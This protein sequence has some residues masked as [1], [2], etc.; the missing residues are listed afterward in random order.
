M[1]QEQ[2]IG[3]LNNELEAYIEKMDFRNMDTVSL[4]EA[5]ERI[6]RMSK[7]IESLQA[8][9]VDQ[10]TLLYLTSSPT[11]LQDIA[12]IWETHEEVSIDYE[13]LS[14]DYF[15]VPETIQDIL[16]N[17]LFDEYQQ[18]HDTTN[19]LDRPNEGAEDKA[20]FLRKA[21]N[22]QELRDYSAD[23]DQKQQFRAV[24]TIVLSP[25]MYDI[26]RENLLFDWAVTRENANLVYDGTLW[27][28]ALIR[29]TDRKEAICVSPE[30]HDYARYA[31]YIA[32]YTALPL[33]GVPV[34][35]CSP[36]IEAADMKRYVNQEQEDLSITQMQKL[37]CG[38]GEILENADGE[39][40]QYY[41]FSHAMG[42]FA[43]FCGDQIGVNDIHGEPL[44][45]GDMTCLNGNLDEPQLVFRHP[46]GEPFPSQEYV[47]EA[48]VTRLDGWQESMMFLRSRDFAVLSCREDYRMSR[49]I[50]A[51]I[52]TTRQEQTRS[53]R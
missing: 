14:I 27:N 32:D 4:V 3:L 8:E 42:S 50:A 44:S 19:D 43:G 51:R 23:Q 37:L 38:I 7:V 35:Y 26:F 48:G 13:E 25:A 53:G 6:V 17:G 10:D 21:P 16:D 18:N 45:V 9:P 12:E 5:A 33:S 39:Q 30:G 40:D 1:D 41:L 34:E 28:C 46:T 2:F 11:P 49:Q 52:H 36:K 24:K 15:G 47:K 20:M 29:T 31:A 22:I